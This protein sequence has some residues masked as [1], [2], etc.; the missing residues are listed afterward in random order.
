MKKLISIRIDKL[1]LEYLI[2]TVKADIEGGH[3]IDV[4][5][6]KNLLIALE[7][8]HKVNFEKCPKCDNLLFGTDPQTGEV[9]CLLCKHTIVKGTEETPTLVKQEP[10]HKEA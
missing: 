9:F 3:Y 1:E 4:Q 5:R 2:R 7:T 8:A 6:I 10:R